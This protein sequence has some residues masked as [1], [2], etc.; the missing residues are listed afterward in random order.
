MKRFFRTP[1]VQ[2]VIAWLVSVYIGLTLRSMRW[3]FENRAPDHVVVATTS[4]HPQI[5]LEMTLLSWRNHFS[6]DV[7]AEHGSAHIESLCKWGPSTFIHRSRVLPSGRPDEASETRLATLAQEP[8]A[9]LLGAFLWK[10]L[11]IEGVGPVVD[12]CASCGDAAAPLIA[13]NEASGGFLCRSCR[14]GVG[15]LPDTVTLVRQIL[16]GQLRIALAVAPSRATAEVERLATSSVEYHLD[17]RLRSAHTNLGAK[18]PDLPSTIS[19]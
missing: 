7:L 15:V 16:G 12:E 18:R 3:R 19:S 8:T 11:A 10:L 5:E 13:F 6:C 1:W 4:G 9:C 17:R 2:S 14:S